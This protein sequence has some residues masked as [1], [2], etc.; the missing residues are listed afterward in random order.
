MYNKFVNYYLGI[1][2]KKR[3]PIPVTSGA[4]KEN[5]VKNENYWYT[6]KIHIGSRV[7]GPLWQKIR[8]NIYLFYNSSSCIRTSGNFI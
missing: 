1:P 6:R 2:E 7:F 4:K 8:S 3:T 5:K